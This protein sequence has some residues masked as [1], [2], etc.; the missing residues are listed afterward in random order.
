M[1]EINQGLQKLCAYLVRVKMTPSCV[2]TASYV[3]AQRQYNG[4]LIQMCYNLCAI[5]TDAGVEVCRQFTKD[6]V[7]VATA[8][9][10]ILDKSITSLETGVQ[11][12]VASALGP[13]VSITPAVAMATFNDVANAIEPFDAHSRRAAQC[14]TQ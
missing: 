8:K 6:A 11:S 4:E 1:D 9:T 12:E 2:Y 3:V 14:F 5:S 7:A 13:G 10:Q